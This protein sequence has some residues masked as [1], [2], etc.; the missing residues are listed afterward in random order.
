MIRALLVAGAAVLLGASVVQG[1]DE[2]RMRRDAARPIAHL[3]GPAPGGTPRIALVLQDRDC[4]DG[5]ALVR[6]WADARP[7]GTPIHVLVLGDDEPRRRL[8]EQVR[9]LDG[10]RVERL[11][12]RRGAEV[13]A[14]LGYARTPFVI[15]LD[16]AGRLTATAPATPVLPAAL[17]AELLGGA[18]VGKDCADCPR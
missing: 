1:V 8:A 5:A 2:I 10:V 17:V 14:R 4:S 18:P 6:G 16:G 9:P 12:E 15:L 11:P 3:L 13:G 7:E